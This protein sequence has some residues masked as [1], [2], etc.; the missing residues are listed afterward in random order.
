MAVTFVCCTTAAVLDLWLCS[1]L[2][3][4]ALLLVVEL[5]L[6]LTGLV[7]ISGGL[8]I[9]GCQGSGSFGGEPKSTDQVNVTIAS[10][11]Y[12]PRKRHLSTSFHRRRGQEV[13]LWD[14]RLARRRRRTDGRRR[15]CG[16]FGVRRGPVRL[17]PVAMGRTG[18]DWKGQR[19]NNHVLVVSPRKGWLASGLVFA[20]S[21]GG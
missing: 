11:A 10:K 12:P 9:S 21:F 18:L 2:P 7:D 5:H 17:E 6:R 16:H 14:D 19:C 15:D 13:A 8:F 3:C 1:A 4:V 20:R